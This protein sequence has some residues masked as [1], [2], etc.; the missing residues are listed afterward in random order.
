MLLGHVGCVINRYSAAYVCQVRF[1]LKC[2]SGISLAFVVGATVM[3]RRGDENHYMS[4]Y[5]NSSLAR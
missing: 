2:N 4:E 5:D 1:T 3:E